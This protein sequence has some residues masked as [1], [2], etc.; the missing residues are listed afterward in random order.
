MATPGG[1]P[2]ETA[3]GSVSVEA[4]TSLIMKLF[5]KGRAWVGLNI[6]TLMQ[7]FAKEVK[8]VS[9]AIEG[10]MDNADPSTTVD[11]MSDWNR[12]CGLPEPLFELADTDEGRRAEII[13]KLRS[14]GGQSKAY[15][16][17]L[18]ATLGHTVTIKD[19]F[20]YFHAGSHAGD[21]TAGVAWVYTF[22]LTVSGFPDPK[23][24]YTVNRLKPAHTVALFYYTGA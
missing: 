1:D 4:Y 15:F 22:E 13:A 21:L 11:Y 5:P 19:D 6:E 12:V 2:V 23:L 14:T 20:D 9:D 7:A 18:A 16:I 8:R 24:E 17:A 10:I 3:T